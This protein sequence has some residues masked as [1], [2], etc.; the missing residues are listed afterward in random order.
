MI[1]HLKMKNSEQER[2]RQKRL[3]VERE[4]ERG[5]SLTCHCKNSVFF[6]YGTVYKVMF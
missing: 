1:A 3:K 5:I 4:I 2:E 6:L